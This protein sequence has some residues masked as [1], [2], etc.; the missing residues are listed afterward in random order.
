M[1]AGSRALGARE[2]LALEVYLPVFRAVRVI[3][4]RRPIVAKRVKSSV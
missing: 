2:E 3:E 4:F 1:V